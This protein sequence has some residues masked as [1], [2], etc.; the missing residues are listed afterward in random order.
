MICTSPAASLLFARAGHSALLDELELISVCHCFLCL[1]S[2]WLVVL[3]A[4]FPL[5]FPRC[6]LLVWCK[7]LYSKATSPSP[8]G[9]PACLVQMPSVMLRLTCAGCGS[10]RDQYPGEPIF[11]S[12]TGM[13]LRH[14]SII[15]DRDPR[16]W[17]FHGG[18]FVR[19][20][21]LFPALDF[22]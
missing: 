6:I 12:R 8:S 17:C 4:Q 16:V 3:V 22:Y 7:L 1:C 2:V 10:V 11:L 15:A 21:R 14:T 19:W 5:R 20:Q 9:A 13:I 18:A